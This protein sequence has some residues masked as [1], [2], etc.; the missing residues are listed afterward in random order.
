MFNY[1]CHPSCL[2]MMEDVL[3]MRMS[4]G[5]AGFGLYVMILEQLRNSDNYSIKFEPQVLAWSLHEPNVELLT[6]VV[7]DYGLFQISEDGTMSSPWLCSVMAEHDNKRA[8][9]SAAGK[10]SAALRQQSS[11]QVAT[12][13]AAAPQPPCNDLGEN[14]Q[15]INKKINKQ[16]NKKTTPSTIEEGEDV[17]IFSED[18]ISA[19][20]KSQCDL[21]D[22]DKHA[23]G[24]KSDSKHNYDV[25]IA[26]ALQYRLT[27]H[28]F[29]VLNMAVN[30]CAI[31]T[32]RFMAF[33]AALR[34]CKET[35]FKPTFPF[36]YFMSK[37][38]NV[39]A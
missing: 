10:K 9:L 8:K 34:H 21:F 32:P 2:S 27:V 7:Q 5:S 24:M 15:Q 13:L 3:K 14:S 38:K 4:E 33:I 20:G 1:F 18:Y 19:V 37:L 39:A 31:G 26:A 11:N 36:E 30:D 16:T 35:N 28:Q 25:L 23:M 17:D 12:T 6:R 29:V 22:P